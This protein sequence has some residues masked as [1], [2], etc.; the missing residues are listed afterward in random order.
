MSLSVDVRER[1]LAG[2]KQVISV[3][4]PLDTYAWYRQLRSGP[5]IVY[6]ERRTAW[7][8]FRYADVERVL[9]DT[10]TFSSERAFKPDGSVDEIAGGSILG[11]DPPRHRHLR[12]LITR[13]FTLKRVTQLEA[14][15]REITRQLLDRVESEDTVDIVTALAFPLPVMVISELLG[16]PSGDAAQFRSWSHDIV[17]N[18]YELRMQA[19]AAIATYF[20]ALVIERTRSPGADLISEL[21]QGEV[22]GDKL[23]RADVV[24]ACL[25][26]LVAGHETTATLI[27]NAM[28]CFAEHPQAR[29]EVTAQPQLLAG[30]IEE[31]LRCRAVVHWM[32]RVVTRQTRFLGQDLAEGDLVMPMFAAANLDAAQFPDPD[33]FDIRRSPN[34]HMGF[35]FGIHLCLGAALARLEANVA[36]R[37]FLTRFPRAERDPSETLSLRPSYF[38]YALQRYPVK[39]RGLG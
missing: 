16:V 35:G 25:L 26:L 17:G 33:R 3:E 30:A 9:R 11:L 18:N 21:V 10:S 4:L 27:G 1:V 38:V 37:E 12:S 7:L 28:W 29:A 5:P 39:L 2:R 13:A 24:G 34:R 14:R 19:M 8:V 31:I 15:I 22:D 36:L 6:D 32:P 20:D 23:S